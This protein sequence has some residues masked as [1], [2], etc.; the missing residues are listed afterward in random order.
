MS[1]KPIRLGKIKAIILSLL[2]LSS[3]IAVSLNM[4]YN[5]FGQQNMITGKSE[6]NSNA[7][8]SEILASQLSEVSKENSNNSI[9]NQTLLAVNTTTSNNQSQQSNYFPVVD[10]DGP[11][12]ANQ[13]ETVTLDGSGTY[14]PEG[15]N[16]SYAWSQDSGKAVVIND[17]DQPVAYFTTPT[18][19]E[20]STLKFNLLVEDGNGGIGKGSTNVTVEATAKPHADGGGDQTVDEGAWVTLN[21]ED[22]SDPNGDSLDYSWTQT[23]GE[24]VNLEDSSQPQAHFWAPYVY[25][26]ATLKFKLTVNDGNGNSD[27]SSVSVK[28]N[29]NVD[30]NGQPHAD[31][32]GDQT[33]DEGA[34]VTLNGEDSSDP[35]GDSLDYSWTQTSGQNVDLQDDDEAQAHFRAPQVNDDTTLKFQLRVEDQNGRSDEDST[36][37]NVNDVYSGSDQLPCVQTYDTAHGT[38]VTECDGNVPI[39]PPCQPGTI[40]SNC[41]PI[42]PPPCKPGTVNPNPNCIPI[43]PTPCQPGNNNPNCKPIPPTPCQPGNNN[44]NCKP[45]PPTPCQPGNNNPNCKPST[46]PIKPSTK[47]IKPSTQ[48]EKIEI[49]PGQEK[50]QPKKIEQKPVKQPAKTNYKPPKQ[51]TTNEHKSSKPPSN[52]PKPPTQKFKSSGSSGGFKLKR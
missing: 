29:T 8:L 39:L 18:V 47:P 5:A 12:I 51:V 9:N 2:L 44:P 26:D 50:T 31:A 25:D 32:G 27:E 38:Y 52:P 22:S 15:N 24:D 19:S 33:V 17:D 35:N 1:H 16:L 11:T 3:L 7:N 4:R 48:P 43:P 42:P 20:K 49:N 34:W 37:V 14:D 46:K 30:S 40:N 10:A 41:K 36:A 23:S 13:G 6:Q 21:G 45:I 28:V